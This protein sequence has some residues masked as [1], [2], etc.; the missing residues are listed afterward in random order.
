MSTLVKDHPLVNTAKPNLLEGTFDYNLPPL[1]KFDGP[2]I[3]YIEI[4]S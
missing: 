4:F 2:V 3:E 1:I